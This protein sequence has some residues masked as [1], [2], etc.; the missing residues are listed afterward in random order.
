M[1]HIFGEVVFVQLMNSFCDLW[2]HFD[3]GFGGIPLKVQ[4]IDPLEIRGMDFQD[5]LK[6]LKPLRQG[7]LKMS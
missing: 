7:I 1:Q 6:P 2:R 4:G 5:F 3:V